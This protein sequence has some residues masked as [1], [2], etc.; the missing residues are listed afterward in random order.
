MRTPTPIAGSPASK[1]RRDRRAL[2][3]VLVA[4][5]IAGGVGVTVRALPAA[6]AA[7]T[8][9]GGT[10]LTRP[11]P[12]KTS[13]RPGLPPLPF[14]AT[15]VTVANPGFLSWALLDR[16]TG[17]VWGSANQQATTWPA[18]MIKAW[19]AAD[20]LRL[21]TQRG[22]S[23]TT[24]EL[25][26]IEIMIRDSDNNAAQQT[27]LS[28]GGIVSI[29]RLVSL[30]KLQDTRA[31][32]AGWSFTTISSRDTVRMA[33][34]IADGKAAG[35][36]WTGWLLSQMRTVRV[37][38]FGIRDSLPTTLANGVAIK[39]GWMYYDDDN[40][41]HV[42]CMAVASTWAMSVLQRYPSTGHWAEDY[43]KGQDVCRRV[44]AQLRNPA[45]P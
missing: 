38:D 25:H 39:N 28:N 23:P 33:D 13:P 1:P 11:V 20:Y 19:L 27:Y 40:L 42:N 31:S 30:C 16:R 3:I 14:R 9:V 2:L 5:A 26:Q 37:G 35:L 43:A 34:C 7:T 6:H 24:A 21:A 22:H 10:S 17:K 36:R 18:S 8:A 44:A 4:T 45:Y 41:W 12:P 15:T 29:N 32:A